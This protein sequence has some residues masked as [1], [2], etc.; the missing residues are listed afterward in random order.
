MLSKT[1]SLVVY[2]Y[3]WYYVK[4]HVCSFAPIESLRVAWFVMPRNQMSEPIHIFDAVK[5]SNKITR[6]DKEF[7]DFY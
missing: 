1:G 6:R 2:P 5:K 3:S 7:I 4:E